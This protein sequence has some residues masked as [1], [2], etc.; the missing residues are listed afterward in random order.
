LIRICAGLFAALLVS[1]CGSPGPT[2]TPVVTASSPVMTPFPTAAGAT[3]TGPP[4]PPTHTGLSTDGHAPG[5]TPTTRPTIEPRPTPLE[6]GYQ[7]LVVD[8]YGYTTFPGDAGNFVTFGAVLTNPNSDWVVYRMPIQVNFFGADDSYVGGAEVGVTVLPGQTTAVAG[9]VYG[10]TDAVRLVVAAA[11][12]PSPYL[13]FA[14]SGTIAI[15]DV[16]LSRADAGALITGSLT[17]S[18]T[19]D[20]SYLQLFA[21]YRDASGAIVGGGTGAVEAIASGATVPFEIS[22]AQMPSAVSTVEVYWQLGGQL[23]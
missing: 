12:D 7:P 16:D 5:A 3:I 11:E 6:G 4:P 18:L 17:S 19:T 10:A 2:T 8:G 14:S 20:Q 15:N 21:V 1:A 23:P 22:D 9:Q 13:P